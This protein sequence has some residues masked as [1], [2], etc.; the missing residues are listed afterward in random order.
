VLDISLSADVALAVGVASLLAELAVSEDK[1]DEDVILSV[2][3]ESF[4]D[5]N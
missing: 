4:A 3:D 2:A 5:D 1:E